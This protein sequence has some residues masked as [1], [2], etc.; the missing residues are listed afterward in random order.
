MFIDRFILPVFQTGNYVRDDVVSST[1]QL[2][3]ESVNQQSYIVY[4]L[5]SALQKDTADRQP[6][7]QVATWVI[8]E[9]GD[10]LLANTEA[11]VRVRLVEIFII[12]FQN[13]E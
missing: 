3:S 7:T 13:Y 2:I 9:F 11:P 6:L 8:G 1:I 5:W 12:F 10:L 4:E